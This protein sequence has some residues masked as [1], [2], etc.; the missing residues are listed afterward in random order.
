MRIRGDGTSHRIDQNETNG[1]PKGT[2]HFWLWCHTNRINRNL[3][4]L[5]FCRF[6]LNSD[7]N[8]QEIRTNWFWWSKLVI[9]SENIKWNWNRGWCWKMQT[10]I[11]INWLIVAIAVGASN[12]L[13]KKKRKK[14]LKIGETNWRWRSMRVQ[15]E[16]E[17]DRRTVKPA[18]G[19]DGR[20]E[21]FEEDT[22]RDPPTRPFFR[23][24]T[25]LTRRSQH[26]E[27]RR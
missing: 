27:R 17:R 2:R 23:P 11:I 25:A 18:T 15:R 14:I 10:T 16:T 3:I 13:R 20:V 24:R 26:A 6:G 9:Q 5:W 22:A 4:L 21:T 1:G 7:Y 8:K 12:K 19:E